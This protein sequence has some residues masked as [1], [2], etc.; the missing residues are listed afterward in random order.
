M[1]IGTKGL[2]CN[3]LSLEWSTNVFL[4]SKVG[5]LGRLCLS[6]YSFDNCLKAYT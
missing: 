3:I 6:S 4:S 1:I 5:G 2:I